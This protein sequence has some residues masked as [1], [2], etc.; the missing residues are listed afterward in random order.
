MRHGIPNHTGNENGV[1]RANDDR[2]IDLFVER[3]VQLGVATRSNIKSIL[4]RI[5]E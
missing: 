1:D 2:R 4:I 3:P 5:R